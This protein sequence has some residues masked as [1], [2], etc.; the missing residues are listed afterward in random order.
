MSHV[1]AVVLRFTWLGREAE[2]DY[3]G[4]WGPLIPYPQEIVNFRDPFMENAYCQGRV[5]GR[6]FWFEES[7]GQQFSRVVISVE[8]VHTRARSG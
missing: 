8:G 6:E 4:D 1:V 2:L 3:R 5:A 7:H